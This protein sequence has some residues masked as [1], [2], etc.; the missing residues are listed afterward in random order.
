MSGRKDKS[1]LSKFLEDPRPYP[2][3]AAVAAGLYPVFF[4]F[5]NN[6]TL[7][8]SWEHLGYF[9]LVFLVIPIIV[10]IAANKLAGLTVFTKWQ[11]YVLPFLNMFVFLFL[12]KLCLYAGLQKKLILVIIVIAGLFAWFLHRHLKKVMVLQF[13]LAAIV[14]FNLVPTVI[15]QL[16]QSDDWM[17]LPDD[18]TAATFTK[19]P[20]VY[21]IQPDGYVNFSEIDKGYYEID[22]SEFKSY[23]LAQGFKNYDGFRTNYA[24]TLS[25]NSA[26][27]SM[28]HHYYNRGTSFSE[29]INARD[30]IVSKNAVLEI[31][32]NNGYTS[33]FIAEKPYLLLNRPKLGFTHSNFSYDDIPYIST[34]LATRRDVTEDL[35]TFLASGEDPKF[36]FI[37][38]F[39][40]GHITNKKR[41]SDGKESEKA[42]WVESLTEANRR[43]KELISTI[44]SSDD[45]ALIII[46][47]DHGGFVGLD[48][49]NEIY[50]KITDRDKVYSIFSS[51]LSILWPEDASAYDAGLDSSVNVFRVLFSFLSEN[52]NY[53]S[54]L[55]KDESF[56]VL[57]DS[58]FEGVFKYISDDGSVSFEP[59]SKE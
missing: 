33:H 15:K 13:V 42:K 50:Q 59:L 19:K 26:T 37:E 39:N 9:T 58:E 4:Y 12:L 1:I 10:F 25:S 36:F 20:N 34:G 3:L 32:A 31:F 54:H 5:N 8:N 7:V 55:E 24:S 49:T 38:F 48:Y 56:V 41:N 57:R 28:K 18:I 30:A 52:K 16:N 17:N 44:R 47:G 22:N 6:F 43:L 45:N 14:F 21:F 2:V 51:Q 46:M 35:K 11:K 29:A 40:P 53:L 27:F 23:L